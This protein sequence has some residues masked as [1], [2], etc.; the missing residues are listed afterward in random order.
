M[1][2]DRRYKFGEEVFIYTDFENG[3]PRIEKG[4]VCGAIEAQGIYSFKYCVNAHGTLYYR[5]P[6]AIYKSIDEIKDELTN[7]LEE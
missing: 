7:L 6:D 4:R 3:L 5:L 2:L 1:E